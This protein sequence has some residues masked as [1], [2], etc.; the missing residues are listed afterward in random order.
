MGSCHSL[1]ARRQ[2]LIRW[3]HCLE[4]H[5]VSDAISNTR[6]HHRSKM[7]ASVGWQNLAKMKPT[8]VVRT[9]KQRN[10][11]T[12]YSGAFTL[13]T[14]QHSQAHTVS[15]L[16]KP[17]LLEA[18]ALAGWL[19]FSGCSLAPGPALFSRAPGSI[20]KERRR[21]GCTRRKER[22]HERLN[23]RQNA[24][25]APSFWNHAKCSDRGQR[26]HSQRCPYIL[27]DGGLMVQHQ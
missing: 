17:V 2:D 11:T 9:V 5:L 24:T 14:M 12:P 18:L 6:A 26:A 19:L 1:A 4:H 25:S 27:R 22:G 7:G 15:P 20:H 13:C 8:F 16:H 3:S 21:G 10:F 23:L